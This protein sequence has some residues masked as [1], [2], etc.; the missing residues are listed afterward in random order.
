VE[1]V[2]EAFR[3]ARA[4]ALA[5]EGPSLIECKTY[6]WMG[7]WT[8]DPQ[9]YRTREE[10]EAWKLKCP[11]KRLREVLLSERFTS[12]NYLAAVEQSETALIAEAVAF[13]LASPE[14][15]PSRVMDDVFFQ[16]V[17]S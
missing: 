7:H 17:V 2:D 14:P 15:D 3:A 11:V 9:V 6:R 5:G 12:E 10:V 16:E 13:A 4:R 1:A 8:G